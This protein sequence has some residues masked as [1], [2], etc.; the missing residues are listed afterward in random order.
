MLI[1]IFIAMSYGRAES[2]LIGWFQLIS[3]TERRSLGFHAGAGRRSH[4]PALP[5]PVSP[6]RAA[7]SSAWRPRFSASASAPP[8]AIHR[9]SATLGRRRPSTLVARPGRTHPLVAWWADI[10]PWSALLNWRDFPEVSTECRRPER[11]EPAELVRQFDLQ[12]IHRY[13][14]EAPLAHHGVAFQLDLLAYHRRFHRSFHPARSAGQQQSSNGERGNSDFGQRYRSITTAVFR[15]PYKNSAEGF[16]K[17]ILADFT[18]APVVELASG[19]P[20]NALIGS[21]TNLDFGS[22]TGRPSAEKAEGAVPAGFPPAT[23]SPY[24]S[25]VQFNSLAAF[26]PYPAVPSPPF[27]C[28]GNLGRNAFTRPGYFDIDLRIARKIPVNDR[29]SLQVIADGFNM[30]NRFNV[31]DGNPVCDPTAG[32]LGC[33]AGQPTA[34][35]DPST[36]QFAVKLNW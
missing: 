16:W 12:R 28:S 4:R 19:R 34:A 2:S 14:D 25:Q 8:A 20:F 35:S 11:C 23:T 5:G 29:I 1:T 30:L 18:A 9:P 7:A 10:P 17:K 26:G 33:L 3:G 22:S 24:I 15:S 27:G 6:H 36:F 21:D 31:S 32:A 13:R